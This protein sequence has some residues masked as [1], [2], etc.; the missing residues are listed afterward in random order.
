VFEGSTLPLLSLV[1]L[2]AGMTPILELGPERI[3]EHVQA[4]LDAL[5]PELASLGFTSLRS[6]RP[7]ERSCILSFVPPPGV[8]ITRLVPALRERKVLTSMPDGLLRLA[9]HYYARLSELALPEL[10]LPEQAEPD[11]VVD[12]VR[13]AL[14]ALR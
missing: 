2:E 12:A 9:P 14:L 8:D 1:A 5:E 10:A 6:P 13:S 11:L 7:E 4:Y 3:F